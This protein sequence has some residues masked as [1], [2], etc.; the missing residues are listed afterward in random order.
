[1][2]S[3]Y[4]VFK[5]DHIVITPEPFQLPGY[6]P[7]FQEHVEAEVQTL[8]ASQ[9]ESMELVQ[10][11][12][13]AQTLKQTA[14]QEA[15]SIRRQAYGFG[16]MEGVADKLEDIQDLIVKVEKTLEA[17]QAQ[18]RQEWKKQEEELHHGALRIAERILQKK[19]QMDPLAT[20]ELTRQVMA[21]QRNSQWAQLTVSDEMGTLLERLNEELAQMSP[22]RNVTI[23][24]RMD[25][26]GTCILE[27]AEGIIDA[28]V[29]RQLTNLKAAME[30]IDP[31][32]EEQA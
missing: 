21:L 25:Q 15:Q 18:A 28:S 3:L 22:Q 20:L 5:P 4:R 19:L 29:F 8:S 31:L 10:V 23:L 1:M 12:E 24:R 27:T 17:L 9:E 26:Q 2:I 14:E 16:Y 30:R 6:E 11:Q 32:W 7:T 13:A